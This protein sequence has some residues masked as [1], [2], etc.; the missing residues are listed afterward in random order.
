MRQRLG[1][2]KHLPAKRRAGPDRPLPATGKPAVAR[3]SS[4]GVHAAAVNNT[5]LSPTTVA[6]AKPWPVAAH[7]P[8]RWPFVLARIGIDALLINV[9]FIL[10]YTARYEWEILRDVVT[11]DSYRPLASFWPVELAFTVIT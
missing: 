6:P 11:P 4:Y 1:S 9:A 3:L 10:A 7:R 5:L 8:L 2:T